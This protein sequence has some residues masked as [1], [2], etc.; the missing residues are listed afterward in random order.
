MLREG[1]WSSGPTNRANCS[2]FMAQQK[3]SLHD[4]THI[5]LSM[6]ILS[7]DAKT[8]AWMFNK[9][10]KIFFLKKIPGPLP[11]RFWLS[12][13]GGGPGNMIFQR[14]FQVCYSLNINSNKNLERLLCIYPFNSDNTIRTVVWLLSH[15]R[16][17][18][19]RYYLA[20]FHTTKQRS[21]DVNFLTTTPNSIQQR[22]K[23]NK[24]LLSKYF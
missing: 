13:P 17:N 4:V 12:W 10:T 20:Q 21:Y 18:W 6:S 16:G 24:Y 19:G 7:S 2:Y 3:L 1:W 22:V 8:Q 11:P 23:F 14:A 15:R 9:F 5:K